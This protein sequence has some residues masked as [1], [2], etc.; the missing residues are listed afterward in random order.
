MVKEVKNFSRT[1]TAQQG[2]RAAAVC[3]GAGPV[4]LEHPGVQ[5]LL[6]TMGKTTSLHVAHRELWARWKLTASRCI[7]SCSCESMTVE[8]SG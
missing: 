4:N 3:C 7:L 8:D 6:Q 2:L 1:G 5:K